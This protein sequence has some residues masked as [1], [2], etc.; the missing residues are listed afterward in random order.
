MPSGRAQ[1]FADLVQ[2]G[3]DT[4]VLAE[5][6]V[7]EHATPAVL[8]GALPKDVLVRVFETA[9]VAGQISPKAVLATATPAVLS[10]HVAHDLLWDC[11]VAGAAR[12][13]LVADGG[14][15]AATDDARAYL[16]RCLD[17][18]LMNGTLTPADIVAKVDAKVLVHALPDALTSKLL[19]VTLAAGVMNPLIVVDTLGTAAIA[20]H[21]PVHVVWSVIATAAEATLTPTAAATST[22]AV[23]DSSEIASI[24]VELDDPASAPI[25]LAPKTSPPT[26]PPKPR[27]AEKRP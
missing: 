20:Q 13:N 18:G 7:L 1:W 3:L 9:L 15:P 10:A 26:A 22:P 21:A 14:S 17:S 11:V 8:T 25:P 19:E 16:R 12:A 4:R 23:D 5:A 2:A 6:D 27:P 24:V